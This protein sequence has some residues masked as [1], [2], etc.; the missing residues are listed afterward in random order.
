MHSLASQKDPALPPAF[1]VENSSD[2]YWETIGYFQTIGLAPVGR[3]Q[4]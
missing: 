4:L 2:T 3:Q 1:A